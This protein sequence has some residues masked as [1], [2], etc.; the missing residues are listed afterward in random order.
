MYLAERWLKIED[1]AERVWKE[2]KDN[3]IKKCNGREFF[4]AF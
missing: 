1:G 4:E 2:E 3:E